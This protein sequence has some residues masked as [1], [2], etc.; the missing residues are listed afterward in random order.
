MLKSKAIINKIGPVPLQLFGAV[1]G[2]LQL[3]LGL[4]FMVDAAVIFM[5]G[6]GA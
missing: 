3:A 5:N 2:V 4:Q 6:G 1:F